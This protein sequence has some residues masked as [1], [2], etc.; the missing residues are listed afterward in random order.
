MARTF[1]HKRAPGIRK[2]FSLGRLAIQRWH[3]TRT[4]VTHLFTHDRIETTHAKAYHLKPTAD[5]VISYARK[6]Q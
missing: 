5:R 6:F 4:Q 3:Y 1:Y 2:K